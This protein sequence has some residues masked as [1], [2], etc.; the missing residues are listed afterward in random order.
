MVDLMAATCAGHVAA[1]DR[2]SIKTIATAARF[3][4]HRICNQNVNVPTAGTHTAVVI[5]E[6]PDPV[7]TAITERTARSAKVPA[8][9]S[10]AKCAQIAG[11]AAVVTYASTTE[12]E[13]SAANVTTFAAT[14]KD[15]PCKATASRI[16]VCC[17]I[18]CAS[19]TA[20]TPR[21]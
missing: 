19:S 21:P 8:I 3:V 4:G 10:T 20:T 5:V 1:Q 12:S 14:W 13:T 7:S 9:V 6:E 16:A 2:V 11:H 17:Y 18:T 15:A